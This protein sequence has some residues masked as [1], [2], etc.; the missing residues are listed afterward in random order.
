MDVLTWGTDPW[1]Q[2]ILIRISWDLLYVSFAAGVL[3]VIA[4]AI[5][6]KVWVPKRAAALA[7]HD[8][9]GAEEAAPAA[10]VPARVA[11]HSLAARLFHWVMAAAVLVLLF[12]GFL[13]I[14]GIQ[15]SWITIHWVAGV[16][17]TLSV[18][19]HII[20]AIFFLDFWSIWI[21]PSELGDAGRRLKRTLGGVAPPP[22]KHPKYPLEN[23][24][25][26]YAIMLTGFAVI[27]TGL[28]MMVRVETPLWTLN[29]YLF[30]DQT[31]GLI[32]VTHDLAS[33][34]LV[35]L[36]I[37]HIYFAIRPEKLWITRSMIFGWIDR[38]HYVEHHDP[39]RWAVPP[40]TRK[41]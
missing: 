1:G 5:W 33:V 29:P 34:G 20:H 39:Q 15:F 8:T 12:T 7:P 30:L 14:V 19:Y 21:Y 24:L 9:A 3:F 27:G 16:V 26:H 11:R 35:A 18:A 36:V 6:V 32:Y 41:G 25:Y 23:K 31:W 4:H 17:L 37:S 40:Q 28:V 2:E 13:P 10:N 38:R 22:R